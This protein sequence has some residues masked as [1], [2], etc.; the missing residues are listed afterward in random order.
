MRT[1]I[2]TS[3]ID[4]RYESY[5]MRSEGREKQLLS[6]ILAKGI[7]EPLCGVQ[8]LPA[9][10]VLLLDGFKRLRCVEKLK[11]NQVPFLS[12]GEVYREG[13]LS[14]EPDLSKY[15]ELLGSKEEKGE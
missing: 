4:R 12:L 14:P 15:D 7:E 13:R 2:E 11:I 10:S 5:R 1:E 8:A 3:Q 9:A 6:S